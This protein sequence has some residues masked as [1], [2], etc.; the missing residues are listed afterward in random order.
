M[1]RRIQLLGI[2][3]FI[4]ALLVIFALIELYG[5]LHL[6]V[7]EEFTLGPG[8]LPV[9]Y[10]VGLVIFAGILVVSPGKKAPPVIENP[11]VSEDE[12]PTAG[13]NEAA[14][15]QDYKAGGLTFVLLAVFIVSIYLVGFFGG[16]IVF[17]FLFTKF[18]TRWPLPKAVAFSLIWGGALY[19]GFDHL[20][21]VQL[22]PGILFGS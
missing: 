7:S 1:L 21:G 8:A 15:A 14:P 16:T 9:I 20:L 6:S 19:Y 17:S 10:A 22:D 11:V 3:R 5:A 18:I 12:D 2:E 13:E 4:A